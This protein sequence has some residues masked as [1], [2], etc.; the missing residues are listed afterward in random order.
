M[1][2]DYTSERF[3]ASTSVGI[4]AVFRP[5]ET[6]SGAVRGLQQHCELLGC[7]SVTTSC[8]CANI[9]RSCWSPVPL[10]WRWQRRRPPSPCPWPSSRPPGV[11]V[12][13]TE[14]GSTGWVSQQLPA[15]RSQPCA[16]RARLYWAP[17]PLP[18]NTLRVG[19]WHGAGQHGRQR[20]PGLCAREVSVDG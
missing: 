18:P 5:V 8:W 2:L 3:T 13:P 6:L 4:G 16:H 10:A 1:R 20:S 7:A 11:P 17:S 12:K 14:H 15:P 19:R 9:T